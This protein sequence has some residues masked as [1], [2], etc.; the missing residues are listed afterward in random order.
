ME[1]L[2]QRAKA[3]KSNGEGKIPSG[4]LSRNLRIVPV[5]LEEKQWVS[6]GRRVCHL[7][8][9]PRER[10]VASAIPHGQQAVPSEA[11]DA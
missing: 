5:L 8:S 7:S 10:I 6:L 3:V 1:K 2:P 4:V 9:V 11:A